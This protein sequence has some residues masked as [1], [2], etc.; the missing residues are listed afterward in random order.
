MRRSNS[1]RRGKKRS[2]TIIPAHIPE[3]IISDF[4][5]S[6]ITAN[7]VEESTGNVKHDLELIKQ[8]LPQNSHPL[9][10]QFRQSFTPDAANKV[11]SV[12]KIAT[13]LIEMPTTSMEERLY[14]VLARWHILN[15]LLYLENR[16]SFGDGAKNIEKI[17]L[18]LDEIAKDDELI[19]SFIEAFARNMDSYPVESREKLALAL[20]C[21]A[22]LYLYIP[23]LYA[24]K[25]SEE[26][27][28]SSDVSE[29][30]WE[31]CLVLYQKAVN[32]YK[33][34]NSLVGSLLQIQLQSLL[35][36]GPARPSGVQTSAGILAIRSAL[37]PARTQ[38]DKL[39]T[40]LILKALPP[41]T[42]PFMHAFLSNP[43]FDAPYLSSDALMTTAVFVNLVIALRNHPAAF[44]D[45]GLYSAIREWIGHPERLRHVSKLLL[46]MT[47]NHIGSLS[48]YEKTTNNQL[49]IST[50][51]PLF[52]V[53]FESQKVLV[54][55]Y[56]MFENARKDEEAGFCNNIVIELWQYHQSCFK[57]G[58]FDYYQKAKESD[59][60]AYHLQ[61]AAYFESFS[62]IGERLTGILQ[63]VC[64]QENP[65]GLTAVQ[66]E[67]LYQHRFKHLQ[68]MLKL[69]YA[70]L[71]MMLL[72]KRLDNVEQCIQTVHIIKSMLSQSS[73]ELNSLKPAIDVVDKAGMPDNNAE[74]VR[75]LL[76]AAP[77]DSLKL[78]RTLWFMLNTFLSMPETVSLGSEAVEDISGALEICNALLAGLSEPSVSTISFSEI[79]RIMDEKIPA[80]LPRISTGALSLRFELAKS[81]ETLFERFSK[82]P[83]GRRFDEYLLQTAVGVIKAH[84]TRVKHNARK[85][86][87][88]LHAPRVRALIASLDQA[89][90][91]PSTE[92][93]HPPSSDDADTVETYLQCPI[94]LA[95]LEKSLQVRKNWEQVNLA[96]V[97]R[98][99]VQ[100]TQAEYTERLQCS[101]FMLFVL[102]CQQQ[103]SKSR[104]DLA[105]MYLAL[106]NVFLAIPLQ[107]DFIKN[108][109]LKKASLAVL[110]MFLKEVLYWSE[111]GEPGRANSVL[112]EATALWEAVKELC[113]PDELACFDNQ[114]SST[115]AAKSTRESYPELLAFLKNPHISAFQVKD[116]WPPQKGRQEEADR[117]QKFQSAWYALSFNS[118]IIQKR[119]E[120]RALYQA[121]LKDLSSCEVKTTRD[122][123]TIAWLDHFHRF[124]ASMPLS[125]RLQVH[126]ETLNTVQVP[127]FSQKI[128]GKGKASAVTQSSRLKAIE[129]YNQKSAAK[130]LAPKPAKRTRGVGKKG[131]K[132]APLLDA[133]TAASSSIPAIVV[134]AL[135]A[136]VDN[137]HARND[138][139][140]S[141]AVAST[142][143]NAESSNVPFIHLPAGYQNPPFVQHILE[144]IEKKGYQAYII[145]GFVR[146][147]LL[148]LTPN[149]ADLLT[150]CPPAILQTLFTEIQ[151]S[152][153]CTDAEVFHLTNPEDSS[154]VI[155]ITCGQGDTPEKLLSN[156]DFTVN[157][158]AVNAQCKLLIPF[159]E[160][161]TD[162]R[163]RVLR[164][165]IPFDAS[166]KK[167]PARLL[168][169]IRLCNQLRW[170]LDSETVEAIHR[171]RH[172][173]SSLSL[174]TLVK[175]IRKCFPINADIALANLESF[176]KCDLFPAIFSEKPVVTPASPALTDFI[177]RAFLVILAGDEF[178]RMED[179]LAVAS[180]T[181]MAPKKEI[182]ATIDTWLK[183]IVPEQDQRKAVL[184]KSWL[185]IKVAKYHALS[186]IKMFNPGA[187]EFDPVK[188]LET[189]QTASMIVAAQDYYTACR[190]SFF[191]ASDDRMAASSS[192]TPYIMPQEPYM[193]AFQ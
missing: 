147:T 82:L 63:R 122:L 29:Q 60:G 13:R 44:E 190:S 159:P 38:I 111:E 16:F 113:A 25:F 143:D 67:K 173:L 20:S 78:A 130:S 69:Q 174:M 106:H 87:E 15:E 98:L 61:R 52:Q 79:A 150:D 75:N 88:E 164:T 114:I 181:L 96:A 99:F 129:E 73:I 155:D 191:S 5:I 104:A 178:E 121:W 101:V 109:R 133:H 14:C 134:N 46:E 110:D 17:T 41:K 58:A 145:G 90:Q 3:V 166:I 119:E 32:R 72:E 77:S 105:E 193:L 56:K 120:A 187:C 188:A 11:R 71:N 156:G 138:F 183:R 89:P 117:L 92:R 80:V 24:K 50:D 19:E 76:A 149:D 132:P 59:I 171:V 127:E 64:R 68:K 118:G 39:N 136:S 93:P 42:S 168:R 185:P 182:M 160:S 31:K 176:L 123:L 4:R 91:R 102:R 34:L 162:L 169:L 152:K 55:F 49:D 8:Y 45:S 116:F 172:N 157:A 158:F 83:D 186:P 137:N 33:K 53:Y 148:G 112:S 48:N 100:L 2:A 154:L 161:V 128:S 108:P 18:S 107:G 84:L 57:L 146:D 126:P 124:L 180:L 135:Q 175:Q 74:L 151:K 27:G 21:C 43:G 51:F 85:A 179:L 28:L 47:N 94:F 62:T 95:L 192:N 22:N 86:L 163:N 103:K 26:S 65:E 30:R 184:L 167:D 1:N 115:V 6:A 141:T 170:E 70:S 7:N 35:N 144:T 140:T 189:R 142:A 165:I 177:K 97:S 125:A 36:Q 153:Y 54:F 23:G 37:E 40:E 81:L 10:I 131:R 66:I 139:G 12:V 9:F